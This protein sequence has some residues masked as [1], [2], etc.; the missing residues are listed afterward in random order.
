MK[1][2]ICKNDILK[3]R[4]REENKN[5]ICENVIIMFDFQSLN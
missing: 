5:S 2:V 4:N 3:Y 1:S